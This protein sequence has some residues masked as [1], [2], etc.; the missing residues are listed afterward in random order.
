MWSRDSEARAVHAASS[1]RARWEC[2]DARRDDDDEDEEC[3]WE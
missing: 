2:G 1:D 3:E